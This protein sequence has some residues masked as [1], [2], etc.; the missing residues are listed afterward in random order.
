MDEA[1][2]LFCLFCGNMECVII[3]VEDLH[4]LPGSLGTPSPFPVHSLLGF[5]SHNTMVR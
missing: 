1:K 2:A 3:L 4:P 5:V